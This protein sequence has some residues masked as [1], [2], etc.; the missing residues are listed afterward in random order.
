MTSQSA[1]QDGGRHLLATQT[2]NATYD[3]RF[4]SAQALAIGA[5]TLAET[6]DNGTFAVS[7]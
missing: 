3:I 4:T 6:F 2:V 5:E 1:L 7:P